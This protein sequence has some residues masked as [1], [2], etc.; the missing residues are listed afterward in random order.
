VYR[1]SIPHRKRYTG[2]DGVSRYTGT[3]VNKVWS[4]SVCDRDA[5]KMSR[6]KCEWC[7]K[8]GVSEVLRKCGVCVYEVILCF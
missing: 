2:N 7:E 3:A 6:V 8:K 1:L 4:V 5:A